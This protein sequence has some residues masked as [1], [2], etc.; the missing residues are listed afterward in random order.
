MGKKRKKSF[1]YRFCAFTYRR[2]TPAGHLACL[3]KSF[4]EIYNILNPDADCRN[5]RKER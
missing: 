2:R 1:R 5:Q 3:R 4:C